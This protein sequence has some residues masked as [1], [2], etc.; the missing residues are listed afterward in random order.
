[1][2]RHSLLDSLKNYH[3]IS[4]KPNQGNSLSFLDFSITKNVLKKPDIFPICA[5]YF[6]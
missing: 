6:R 2:I 4:K 3:T 5:Y 1:M